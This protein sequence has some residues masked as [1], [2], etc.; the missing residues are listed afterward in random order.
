[1]SNK[2]VAIIPARGGS[3]RLPRKNLYPFFGRPLMQWAVEACRAAE[4]VDDVF[5]STEDAEIAALA[6]K[7]GVGVIDR[8]KALAE[9]DVW[10]QEVLK[11]AVAEL[12]KRG[13]T[14]DVIVRVQ[15]N[16]PQVEGAKIDEAVAK[17]RTADRWEIFSVDEEGFE[18]AAIHVLRRE[19]VFQKAF[20]VYKGVVKTTYRDVH[21][22]ED[23]EALTNLRI[24]QIERDSHEFLAQRHAHHIEH[25]WRGLVPAW[26]RAQRFYLWGWQEKVP[27][28]RRWRLIV[29]QS[30]QLRALL[31][32]SDCFERA[33]DMTVLDLGCGF[34]MYWP[35]LRQYGFRTFVGVDLFD[36]R[37]QQAYL[38]GAEEFVRQFCADCETQIIMDDV[39]NLEQ[40]TL[41]ADKFDVVLNVATISTKARSTGIPQGLF[42]TILEQFGTPT[43]VPAHIE[44]AH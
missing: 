22:K 43:T 13:H 8:P 14:Y 24:Q 32:S 7:L 3:K 42:D 25:S 17:L 6:K 23:I 4:L 2:V 1:M 9:D 29:E 39:R 27:L 35:I 30:P 12:E 19:V 28:H 40:H 11:H 41:I 34:A 10:T 33:K 18:D 36:M 26:V 44:H 15:A 37:G 38:T 5:V 21:T 20:S 16:S 31:E